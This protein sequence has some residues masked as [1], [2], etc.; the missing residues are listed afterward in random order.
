[1][2]AGYFTVR[3]T[4]SEVR[5]L[6]ICQVSFPLKKISFVRLLHIS[7]VLFSGLGALLHHFGAVYGLGALGHCYSSSV[8]FSG[9]G[10]LLICFII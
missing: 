3:F 7:S 2:L 10:A 5:I 9:V 1:M 4:T 6:T 8:L